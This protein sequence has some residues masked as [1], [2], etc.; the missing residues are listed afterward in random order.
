MTTET[1][2]SGLSSVL[3]PGSEGSFDPVESSLAGV[4][5]AS[6]ASL[7]ASSY[8]TAGQLTDTQWMVYDDE[9][10]D[11]IFDDDDLDDDDEDEDEDDDDD[12]DDED[13]D[14]DDDDYDDDDIDFDD[15]DD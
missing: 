3:F 7:F 14:D 13:F 15:D 6:V 11:D 2:R 12:L 9:D 10:D 1:Y 5:G 8:P 4:L